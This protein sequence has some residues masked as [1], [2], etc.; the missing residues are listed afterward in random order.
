MKIVAIHGV[1]KDRDENTKVIKNIIIDT[2]KELE[3]SI[4]DIDLYTYNIPFYEG[5]TTEAVDSIVDKIKQAEGFIWISSVQ[6]LQVSGIIKNFLEY[7]E[8]PAYAYAFD[9]KFGMAVA[10]SQGMGERAVGEYL[11]Q[12]MGILGAVEAAKVTVA[13]EP[14]QRIES[15]EIWKQAVEKEAEGFYRTIRQNRLLLPSSE[16][17]LYRRLKNQNTST[18]VY[19]QSAQASDQGKIEGIQGGAKLKQTGDQA[20]ASETPSMGGNT[21]KDAIEVYHTA[22]EAFTEQ[23]AQ[24]IEQLTQLFAQKLNEDQEE[25]GYKKPVTYTRPNTIAPAPRAKTCWQMT[26]SLPHYFQP[27][28]AADFSGIFQLK[29]TGEE[30]FDGYLRIQNGSCECTDGEIDQPDVVIHTSC[31]IWTEILKGKTSAQKAFMTG[32]LKVRGNFMLLNKIDQLFKK[33]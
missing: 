21:K 13:L 2:L 10:V 29:I 26:Q 20:K 4:E 11:L 3:V 31:D 9:K 12:A 15:N 18:N 19:M 16:S 8:H 5:I 24:D 28:L 14:E 30:G 27:H 22:F 7:C 33:M 6:M 25:V 1:S 32:Q 23:Q 17:I